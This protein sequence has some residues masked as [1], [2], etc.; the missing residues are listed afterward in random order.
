MRRILFVFSFILVFSA[1]GVSWNG[2]VSAD[3]GTPG[4]GETVYT[5]RWGDTLI[6][7]AIR[8]HTTVMTIASR[9][10]ITNINLIYIGQK[11]IISAPGT[12][13][14]TPTATRTPSPA[15][16]TPTATPTAT[17]TPP[18]GTP[19]GTASST[20]SATPS[21]TPSGTITYR[22]QW[23][24]TLG[25]IA[26]RFGTTVQSIAQLNGITNPNL[27]Y[28]GQRL[29]ISGTPPTPTPTRTPS[30][31]PTPLVPAFELGGHV[32]GFSDLQQ[33]QQAGM[34]WAK[35][36]IRWQI[37]Q[38]PSSVESFVNAARGNGF[39]VMLSISG[40]PSEMGTDLNAYYQAFATFVGSVASAYHP[41]A[42]EVWNEPN[43]D[44]EWPAGRISPTGY[45]QMLRLA[46]Q[47]IKQGSPQTMVIS[48][49]P[50][51]TGYFGG[52]C[53]SAG[54]DDAPFIRQMQQ[55]GAAQ[56]ADCIGIHYNEG[57]LSPDAT[58]GDPRGN[59]NHYTR[60]YHSMVNTY[61][62]VFPNKPLCFTELG[63]LT[64]EGL[65][66]LPAAFAWASNTT[67]QEQADWLARAATLSRQSG[68]IRLMIV[69]NVDAT[70]Y[71]DSDPQAGYAIVRN[72]QCLACGTL[73]AAMSSP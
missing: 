71:V 19:S 20:P 8:F 22:V 24:D 9:N 40:I 39:K 13:T 68:H 57:I 60:Y 47:A 67:V 29:I 56:Y 32:N 28:I 59:P 17:R 18:S 30:S 64:P 12:S 70:L 48:A 5:V 3:N 53:T 49:A 37:G 35:T 10:N 1:L 23:G 21:G 38:P 43:I 45:T 62:G 66:P 69:W 11:L 63:Y 36:Q 55:A 65:G 15:T 52:A 27:I 33:M 7:I 31:S 6:G 61:A 14:A 46:Y 4:P 42:I 2:T 54:C 58:S 51:P 44:R 72:G 26:V 41:D 16:G 34:T 73:G 50:A 25:S